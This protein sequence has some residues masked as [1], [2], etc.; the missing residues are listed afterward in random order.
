M[1][2]VWH[3]LRYQIPYG[4][5]QRLREGD[6]RAQLRINGRARPP[7]AALILLIDVPTH[8]CERGNG[9][10]SQAQ[11]MPTSLEL[12]A[13]LFGHLAPRV[14]IARQSCTHISSVAVFDNPVATPVWHNPSQPYETFTPLTD[15]AARLDLHVCRCA[16]VAGRL[17]A[18][19]PFRSTLIVEQ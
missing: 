12:S 6:E 19:V 8:A 18:Q 11:S 7:L 2:E 17:D 16:S 14:V 9:S 10:L 5:V 1:G 4:R 3:V 15:A 13:E